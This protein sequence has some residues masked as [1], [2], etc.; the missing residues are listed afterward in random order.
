MASASGVTAG[1]NHSGKSDAIFHQLR[2]R[3]A[4]PTLR[5]QQALQDV[6][7]DRYVPVDSA[8]IMQIQQIAAASNFRLQSR[9]PS[10]ARIGLGQGATVAGHAEIQAVVRYF[11]RH[12]NSRAVTVVITE[13]PCAA[14]CQNFLPVLAQYFHAVIKV[15]YP[16]GNQT[17]GT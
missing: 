10:D 3:W 16:G 8:L 7:G 5:S 14:S 11:G 17:F 1:Y 15:I 6:L 12:P 2:G 13:S 9:Q 4:K